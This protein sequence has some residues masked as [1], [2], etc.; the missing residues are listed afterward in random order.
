MRDAVLA[1]HW[2]VR[3][4]G[5]ATPPNKRGKRFA[6]A[7]ADGVR[8]CHAAAVAAGHEPTVSLYRKTLSPCSRTPQRHETPAH[9]DRVG[10]DLSGKRLCLVGRPLDWPTYRSV[11]VALGGGR[12]HAAGVRNAEDVVDSV[13]ARVGYAQPWA[14]LVVEVDGTDPRYVRV[15]VPLADGPLADRY[16]V[17]REDGTT[18]TQDDADVRAVVGAALDRALRYY[19]LA[20]ETAS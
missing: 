11:R 5:D 19:G 9:L 1:E 4:M 15:P 17:V 14:T 13:V 8:A 12:L 20:A 10:T 16:E 3:P 2:L 7:D 6:L 18:G